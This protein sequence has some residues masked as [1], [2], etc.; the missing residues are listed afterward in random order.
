MAVVIV[1]ATRAL[2]C[3]YDRI[4]HDPN[5]AEISKPR[6][7]VSVLSICVASNCDFAA[8]SYHITSG[9]LK[10]YIYYSCGKLMKAV[11]LTKKVLN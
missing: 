11:D 7:S 4:Y 9:K 5:Y 6:I 3:N 2:A 8:I 1:L 10:I